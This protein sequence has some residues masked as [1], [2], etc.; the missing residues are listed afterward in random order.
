MNYRTLSLLLALVA[1]PIPTVRGAD[2]TSLSAGPLAVDHRY[3]PVWWQTL[4]CL[5]DDWQKTLVGKEGTLL[6]DYPG[7]HSGFKTRI[8]LEFGPEAQ[9]VRQELVSPRV[10]IVRTV[11]RRGS[12]EIVEEAFA[13]APPLRGNDANAARPAAIERADGGDAIRDWAHPKTPCDPA[14][15]DI[16]VSWTGDYPVRY[17]VRAEKGRSYTIVVGL[18]EGWHAQAGQRILEVRIEGRMRKTVDMVAAYGQNVP[19]LFAFDARDED[20]DGWIDLSVGAAPGAPDRNAILNVLW[21]FEGQAPPSGE[22]LSGRSGRLPLGHVNCGREP[23]HMGPA[24]HDLVLARLRNTGPATTTV[25]PTVSIESEAEVTVEP[26]GNRVRIGLGT[27]LFFPDP[28]RI[29]HRSGATSVLKWP[30]P[31]DLPA[32]AEKTLTLGVLRGPLAPSPEQLYPVSAGQA[33]QLAGVARRYWETVDLPYGRIEVPDAGIQGQLDSSIRNIY[34]AREIRKGLPAFQVGPTCYRGLWVVDGSFLMEAVAYLGR[35]E[36]ARNGIRYLLSF[37]R[38]D[39]A[40]MLIDGHLKETGIALWAVTRHAR[41]TGDRAWLAERWPQLEK[42]FAFIRTLRKAASADPRAPYYRLLPEGYSDGGLGGKNPEYTNVY[43]TLAGLKAAADAARW[44]GKLD[45]AGDWQ[46]EY[47]DFYATF[48]RAAARD[49]RRDSHGNCYLPISMRPDAGVSPQKAQWAFLHAVFP[50]KVF[51]TD[52][53]LVLG[54]LAML[55]AAECEGLVRDTGWVSQGLWGYF[56]SFYAHGWLWV[57]QGEKAAQTL[58]A[59]ANHA[60][61]LLAWREEQMPQ[62]EG[63]AICGDMPHNWASAEFIRLVRHLLVLERGDQLHL[64]EGLPRGWLRPGK[65]IRVEGVTTEFGPLSLVLRVAA[66]GSSAVLSVDPPRRTPPERIVVHLAGLGGRGTIALPT[67]SA[68][69]REI[70]LRP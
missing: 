63:A 7:P 57:G 27:T 43:W 26:G 30:A 6:Y 50:G 32:G 15:R 39:G 31:I 25:R 18:C 38:P 51:A 3:A 69:Q 60:S 20:G 33:R 58:Y 46:R 12:L 1:C 11:K 28:V 5:P 44:L 14:F 22:L 42:G 49:A 37:Q 62:G 65:S 40:I 13:A 9:W 56:G 19:A 47:D 45:Q 35:I 21:A 17:R 70:A 24:R 4:I 67:D 53:P 16:A 55:R 41:L 68:S 34:Q 36:E 61:P 52:D 8:G 54:N 10:P 29:A 23:P 66:D 64:F 59:M 2:I 48:R